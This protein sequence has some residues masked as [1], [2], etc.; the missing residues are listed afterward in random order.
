MSEA[1]T[2]F[3]VH[4]MPWLCDTIGVHIVRTEVFDDNSIKKYIAE[5]LV[6]RELGMNDM[7]F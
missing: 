5:P 6:F 2:A 3:K 7:R 4:R 1:T